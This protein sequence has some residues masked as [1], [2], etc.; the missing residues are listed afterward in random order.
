MRLIVSTLKMNGVFLTLISN[1]YINSKTAGIFLR[2]FF[3]LIEEKVGKNLKNTDENKR[4][5]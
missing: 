1:K 2:Q 3:I 4:E 5:E